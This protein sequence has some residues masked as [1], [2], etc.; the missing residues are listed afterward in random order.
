MKL[1][2]LCTGCGLT[3]KEEHETPD[4]GYA[5]PCLGILPGV[6]YACCGHGDKVGMPYI[7]FDNGVTMR[8][9]GDSLTEVTIATFSA[10]HAFN[11]ETT[12]EKRSGMH[13]K[14]KVPPRPRKR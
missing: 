6:K 11:D 8:F 5:D 7:F 1:G 12:D 2:E 14:H 4:G 3:V 9:S 10:Y 13:S